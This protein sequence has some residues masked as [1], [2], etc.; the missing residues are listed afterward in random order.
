MEIFSFFIHPSF[1]HSFNLSLSHPSSHSIMKLPFYT[2]QLVTIKNKETKT[3]SNPNRHF[4]TTL[5]NDLEAGKQSGMA[6]PLLSM[7]WFRCPLVGCS[8]HSHGES[9]IK[10][11]WHRSRFQA[12]VKVGEKVE[13]TAASF[14]GCDWKV[15]HT[16]YHLY[17]NGCP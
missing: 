11:K 13:N 1:S 2:V 7:K 5:G 9:I 14:G 6:W 3:F 17:L 10:G 8:T 16:V 12:T 15:S 4:F